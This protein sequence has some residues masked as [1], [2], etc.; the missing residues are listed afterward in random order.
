M[1]GKATTFTTLLSAALLGGCAAVPREAGFMEVRATVAERT[2]GL[3]MHWNQGGEADAAVAEEVRAMATGTLT[4]D[5]AVQIALLNNRNLQATYE[6]LMIAQA[7]LVAAGLL[8]NPVFDAEVRFLE[9][10]EGVGYEFAVVQEFL[11]IFQIPLRKRIAGA[12]F[13]AA[14]LRVA[15]EAVDLAADMREAFYDLVA[16]GQLAEMR[17]TVLDATGASYELARRLHEAGNITDLQLDLERAQHEQAKLDLSAAEYEVVARRETVNALMG[18]YGETV[19]AWQAPERLPE[20][21]RQSQTTTRPDGELERRAIASSLDLGALR[22]EIE[23]SGRV[24]GLERTFGLV[25]ELEVGGTAER[26]AEDGAWAGGPIIALPIPLFNQ[27]QPQIAAAAAE[28]RRSRALYYA[29]AVELRAAVR[30]ARAL[31][32]NAETRVRYYEQVVLPLRAR[33]VEE[34]QLQYNAMLVGAFE[35]LQAR[36]QQI[37]AGSQY[38]ETLREYWLARSA[39]ETLVN[40][41]RF[42]RVEFDSQSMRSG[43]ADGGMGNGH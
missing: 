43:D 6:N 11:G 23:S 26:E 18:V 8:A 17:R 2:G 41:G 19:T 15:G 39:L 36:Q 10:G 4:A 30:S 13:E 42:R 25:P 33:I 16:A 29:T 28:L 37:A 24:L 22:Q 27:G 14:K 1:T 31:V 21:P 9:S 34:T 40:G 35:L 12:R 38:I 20:L 3:R 5:E 32:E 7:D